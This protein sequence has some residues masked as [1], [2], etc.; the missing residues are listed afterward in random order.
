VHSINEE[1]K[2]FKIMRHLPFI[3]N[4]TFHSIS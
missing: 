3:Y 4:N 2:S 1:K